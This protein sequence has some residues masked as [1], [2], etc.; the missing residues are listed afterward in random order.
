MACYWRDD[1]KKEEPLEK[2]RLVD[3]L[4]CHLRVLFLKIISSGESLTVTD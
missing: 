1:G 4:A 3:P 2:K